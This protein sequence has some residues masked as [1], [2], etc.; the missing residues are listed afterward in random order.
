VKAEFEE[1]EG[2]GCS[3]K[4]EYDWFKRSGFDAFDVNAQ[5]SL[6]ILSSRKEQD[7]PTAFCLLP[8]TDYGLPLAMYHQL[9]KEAITNFYSDFCRLTAVFSENTAHY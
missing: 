3:D 4:K 5:K 9:L 1:S 2:L 7:A 8:S 6:V